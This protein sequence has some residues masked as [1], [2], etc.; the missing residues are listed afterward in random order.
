MKAA[1][2]DVAGTELSKDEADFFK[3]AQPWAFILFGR[4]CQTPQQIKKLCDDIRN[5]VNRDCLI[6]LDQEGG[7]VQRLKPPQFPQF[8]PNEIYGRLFKNN[9]EDA[10]EATYLHH[11]L[12]AAELRAVGINADCAPCVDLSINGAHSVIGDRA[13]SDIPKTI[14]KL[15]QAAING[16]HDGKVASVIKHIPGHGRARADSHHELPVVEESLNDLQA[17]F[18]PFKALKDAPMAM[19][20]HVKYTALDG[21]YC[22]TLSQKIIKNLIRDEFGFNGLLMTDDI[23]MK[24]LK[25]SLTEKAQS[26]INAGCDVAMLCNAPL[27]ER[28]EFVGACPVL[29]GIALERAIAAEKIVIG[30]PKSFNHEDAWSRFA[31]LTGIEKGTMLALA[32]D[33]TERV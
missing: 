2:I 25:G 27:S 28:V 32:P 18:I 9:E 6:F 15:G 20:A 19:T 21:E 31:S 16:L 10:L 7:R 3:S 11:L 12:I 5:S 30:V 17:D 26:S 8:P 14:S 29:D 33:P 24:A 4:S 22:A 23:S 13:F 1:I